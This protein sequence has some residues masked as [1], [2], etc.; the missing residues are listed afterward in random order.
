MEPGRLSRVEAVA[1]GQAV[2]QAQADT[3]AEGVEIIQRLQAAGFRKV[4]PAGH[5]SF[6]R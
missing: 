1:V 4:T 2:Q 5:G 6:T 3:M